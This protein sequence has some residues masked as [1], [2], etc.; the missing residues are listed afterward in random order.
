MRFFCKVFVLQKLFSNELIVTIVIIFGGM[1][2]FFQTDCVDVEWT[3]AE[4]HSPK[5]SVDVTHLHF[6]CAVATDR[7]LVATMSS[8]LA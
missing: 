7:D 4:G 1:V 5:R 2:Y 6:T 3:Y 8:F